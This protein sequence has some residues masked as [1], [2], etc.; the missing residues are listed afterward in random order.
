[1]KTLYLMRHAKSSW[2]NSGLTDFDRPL[3]ERGLS[4]APFIGETIRKRDLLPEVIIASP[5]RRAK[6]TAEL[7]KSAA[8]IDAELRFDGRIYAAGTSELLDV[9]M[10]LGDEFASA[11]LVGHNP[12]FEN[13]VRVLTGE[14]ETMPTASI[15]VIDLEIEKWCDIFVECGILR[16]LLRPKE[17]N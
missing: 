1:M 2:E 7:V 14:Y 13:M 8:Q 10:E 9:A 15:A 17:L 3:N 16:A 5:A 12:G 4:V 11:M 6:Q